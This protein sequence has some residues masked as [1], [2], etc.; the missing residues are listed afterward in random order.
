MTDISL[1]IMFLSIKFGY[2]LSALKEIRLNIL[3]YWYIPLFG[4]GVVGVV[5]QDERFLKGRRIVS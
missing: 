2:E 1:G 3:F 4:L 5:L